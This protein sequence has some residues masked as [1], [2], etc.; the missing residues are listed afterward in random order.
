MLHCRLRWVWLLWMIAG[1][2]SVATAQ[3]CGKG[4]KPGGFSINGITGTD[5]IIGC[6][7]LTVSLKNTVAGANP[8]SYSYDYKGEEPPANLTNATTFTYTKPGKY[9]ILQ[10]GSSNAG[11]ITLCREVI[12]RDVTPPKVT[13]TACPGGIIKLTFADDSITRQYDQIELDWNDG[14]A[15]EYINKGE[16][17]Q[18]EHNFF[19]SGTRV[20]R[21]RATYKDGNCS[22]SQRATISVRVD[23]TKVENVKI[24][25]VD[26]R[27]DGSVGLSFEGIAGVESEV[28]VKKGTGNYAGSGVKSSQAGKVDLTLQSLDPKQVYCFKIASTDACGNVT[29]SNEI[30]T[31]VLNGK[32]ESERN[33]ITWSQYPAPPGFYPV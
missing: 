5:P 21:Y 8:I 23:G 19:G 6:A 11:S 29:E 2:G 25:Q 28:M 12:V 3:L 20:I 14:S 15:S 10:V 32:A 7:P 31:V 30:C 16:T 18:K 4:E 9:R 27:A 33:I 24:S 26:A 1:M 22:G 17:L 13:Y